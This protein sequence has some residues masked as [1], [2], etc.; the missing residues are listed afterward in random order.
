[1]KGLTEGAGVDKIAGPSGMSVLFPYPYPY[2]YPICMFTRGFFHTVDQSK[3]QEGYKNLALKWRISTQAI[4]KFG[5]LY[6][7]TFLPRLNISCHAPNSKRAW[8]Y[9]ALDELVGRGLSPAFIR[10]QCHLVLCFF[11]L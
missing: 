2:V 7:R 3:M 10:E 8:R 9:P 1:M 6:C 11:S 4:Q 5:T